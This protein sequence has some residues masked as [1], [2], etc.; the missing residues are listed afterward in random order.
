[1]SGGCNLRLRFVQRVWE[2]AFARKDNCVFYQVLQLANVANPRTPLED[3]N[4]FPEECCRLTSPCGGAAKQLSRNAILD[5]WELESI[6]PLT[7]CCRLT[8]SR[9]S[10]PCVADRTT[11]SVPFSKSHSQHSQR[12]GP[13]ALLHFQC[14][15]AGMKASLMLGTDS[16]RGKESL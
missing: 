4:V 12:P 2:H 15:P 6:R 8:N 1:L 14:C 13:Q 10:Q 11:S 3:S 7:F 9:V 16:P 5:F